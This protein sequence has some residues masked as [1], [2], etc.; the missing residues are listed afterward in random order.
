[1]TQTSHF[2]RERAKWLK[3]VIMSSL[4]G[5]SPATEYKHIGDKPLHPFWYE[6]AKRITKDYVERVE[7]GIQELLKP[8]KEGAIQ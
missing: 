1:M 6:Q 5:L 8:E 3:A 2:E 7:N 4:S